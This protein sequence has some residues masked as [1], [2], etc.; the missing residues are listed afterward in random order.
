MLCLFTLLSCGSNH[1]CGSLTQTKTWTRKQMK[2]PRKR[3]CFSLNF[4][5]RIRSNIYLNSIQYW[6]SIRSHLCNIATCPFEKISFMHRLKSTQSHKIPSVHFASPFVGEL[7]GFLAMAMQLWLSY[8]KTVG[9]NWSS[10]K[11]AINFLDQTSCWI[12]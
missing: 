6:S 12:S 3:K 2:A 5:T 11:S 9:L 4:L 8:L 10:P 1:P 7:S